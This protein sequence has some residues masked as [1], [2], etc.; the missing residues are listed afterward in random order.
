MLAAAFYQNN[1]DTRYLH[2]AHGKTVSLHPL[3]TPP[4][5]RQT[6]SGDAVCRTPVSAQMSEFE[7]NA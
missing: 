3:S 7:P 1:Y 6:V 5:R 2:V 4:L